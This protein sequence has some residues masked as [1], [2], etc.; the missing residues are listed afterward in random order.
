MASLLHDVGKI[1]VPHTILRKPG[2]LTDAEFAIVKQHV[3]LGE[4]LIR[5]IPSLEE[6][7]SAVVSHHERWDG[8]GYPHGLRGESI[9]LLGRII[10]VADAYSAMTSDR[11]YRKSLSPEEAVAELR[12]CAGTQ[13][14]PQLVELFV[15]GL[16]LRTERT[17]SVEAPASSASDRCLA[18][19]G[20]ND[21]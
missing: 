3:V 16:T 7:R 14:D 19:V 8:G 13:F 10:A 21:T 5:E 2:R 17:P 6:V 9:P 18:R 11:P 4:V 15:A 20:N 1:G 12:Q